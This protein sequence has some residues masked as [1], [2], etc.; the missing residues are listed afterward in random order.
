M[1]VTGA[2]WIV[3]Y[4]GSKQVTVSEDRK[5]RSFQT[6]LALSATVVILGVSGIGVISPSNGGNTVLSSLKGASVFEF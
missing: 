6:V 1:G 5:M 2:E 4:L 3:G